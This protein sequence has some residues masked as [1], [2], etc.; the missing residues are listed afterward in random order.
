MQMI[1]CESL[2]KLIEQ[3]PH[4]EEL[5][6][7]CSQCERFFQFRSLRRDFLGNQQGCAF[8]DC[9]GAGFDV[10]IQPWDSL[11]E[12]DDPRWP[13]STA[14]L[15]HGLRSPSMEEF[16]E[17]V[18]RRRLASVLTRFAASPELAAL[19]L[20]APRWT[21]QFLEQMDNVSLDPDDIPVDFLDQCFSEVFGQNVVC[22]VDDVPSIVAEL[23]AYFRFS[24]RVL[25]PEG[26][27]R[28]GG[29]CGD[30]AAC[31]ELLGSGALD[32]ALRHEIGQRPRR[33]RIRSERRKREGKASS[34]SGPRPP[35]PPGPPS[36][37]LPS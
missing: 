20:S 12:E 36:D 7:W 32:E 18:D 6:L 3:A 37:T 10:N 34:S 8:A 25:E 26:E 30:A 35:G 23:A 16:Y 11:R 13:T 27:A 15:H 17:Q 24:A 28:D 19:G 2:Y 5:W 22:K 9:D 4:P 1:I 31:A 33:S 14:Q 21:P 29:V